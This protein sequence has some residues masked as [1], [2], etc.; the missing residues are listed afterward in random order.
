MFL[1]TLPRPRTTSWASACLTY[2]IVITSYDR[3][4]F[5]SPG[6]SFLVPHPLIY[7]STLSRAVS[8]DETDQYINK[9]LTSTCV[10]SRSDPQ[11]LLYQASSILWI[12]RQSMT[13]IRILNSN[14]ESIFRHPILDYTSARSLTF[15][16][17]R[18]ATT[19]HA[20]RPARLD[21]QIDHGRAC[22]PNHFDPRIP[23]TISAALGRQGENVKSLP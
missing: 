13:S 20:N 19:P 3:W 7:T 14:L 10:P 8:S 4:I 2:G 15:F 6:A 1:K 17:H 12:L 16:G 11:C 9:Y 21:R 18:N 22:K 5:G 23:T